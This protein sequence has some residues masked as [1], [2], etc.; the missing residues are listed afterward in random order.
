MMDETEAI[1]RLLAMRADPELRESALA[2]MKESGITIDMIDKN[3]SLY[4]P[5]TD[6]EINKIIRALIGSSDI[7]WFE[8]RIMGYRIKRLMRGK[9]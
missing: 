1:E 9:K 8:K 7:S 6:K 3:S 4:G 5:F 2:Y